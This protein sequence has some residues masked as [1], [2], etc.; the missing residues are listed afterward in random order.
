MDFNEENNIEFKNLFD[1]ERRIYE[2]ESKIGINKLSTMP[3]VD[4]QTA[5]YDI[6][7]KLSLLDTNRLEGIFRRV[8]VSFNIN[9]LKK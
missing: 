1:L 2:I 4:I 3:Y 6:S 9:L 5:I 8:Q 7:Q